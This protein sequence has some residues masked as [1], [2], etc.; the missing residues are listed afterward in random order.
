MATTGIRWLVVLP[1]LLGDFQ[2]VRGTD[3]QPMELLAPD[4]ASALRAAAAR[5]IP[6]AAS[7]ISR[8]EF[9]ELAR[10]RPRQASQ[11]PPNVVRRRNRHR[12][13]ER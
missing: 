6:P 12:R 4:R 1:G 8:L 7:V 13:Q 3:G 11:E 9:E 2:P 5:G 10:R